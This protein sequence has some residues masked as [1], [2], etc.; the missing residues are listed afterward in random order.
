MSIRVFILKNSS[1]QQSPISYIMFMNVFCAICVVV[2]CLW[3][4]G[5]SGG[6]L[7]V[8]VVCKS[9]FVAWKRISDLRNNCSLTV[10]SAL[11]MAV[12][13]TAAIRMLQ[14]TRVL[15]I[16]FVIADT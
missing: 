6:R 4:L 3:P 13:K 14:P 2:C 10:I 16:D 8:R 7:A 12:F 1:T 9:V 15:T 5:R 11:K